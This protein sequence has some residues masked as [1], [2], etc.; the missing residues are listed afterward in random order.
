MVFPSACPPPTHFL[1]IQCKHIKL[2]TSWEQ[3]SSAKKETVQ[4]KYILFFLKC[5]EAVKF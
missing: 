1:L 4:E 2:K 3:L 5:R